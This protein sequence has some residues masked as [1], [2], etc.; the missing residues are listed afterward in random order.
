M[1]VSGV[2]SNWSKVPCSRSRATD[3]AASSKVWIMLNA[4]ISAGIKFQRDSRLGLN[5]ARRSTLT[6]GVPVRDRL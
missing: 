1:G 5:Q 6:A 4:A 3:S 2:T